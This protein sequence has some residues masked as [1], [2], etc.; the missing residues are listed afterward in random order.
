MSNTS[1]VLQAI[2]RAQSAYTTMVQ[3]GTMR[4]GFTLIDDE[5]LFR[6][7]DTATARFVFLNVNGTFNHSE[8]IPE[9]GK[10]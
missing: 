4:D 5:N 2:H 3:T 8:G 10:V 6:W 7:V 9:N 1:P